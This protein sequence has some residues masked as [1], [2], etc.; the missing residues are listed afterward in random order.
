MSTQYITIKEKKQL[1]ESIENLHKKRAQ[2]LKEKEAAMA[3]GDLSENSEY[4]ESIRMI[5]IIDGN[6]M[7][8][9]S[10]ISSANSVD[11]AKLSGDTIK[12]GATV[13]VI[14]MDI[15]KEF[16]YQIVSEFGASVESHSISISSPLGKALIGK[17]TGDYIELS[18]PKG[19]KNYQIINISYI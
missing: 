12:F 17:Q 18:L 8:Y 6:I 13:T 5:C 1:L 19:T 10:I 15:D 9:N 14:D 7:K 2:V 11:P 3:L 4:K 16:T